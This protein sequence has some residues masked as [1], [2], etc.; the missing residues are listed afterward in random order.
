MIYP[1]G[2]PEQRLIVG[3]KDLTMAFDMVLIDGFSLNPP[4][5]KFHTIDIPGGNGSIDL[6]E[7]VGGD[8][9]Y[10]NREQEFT[11]KV[12]YA[13]RF[14]ITK[15]AVSNYLHGRYF[16]YEL[17]WDPGY[18]YKGRFSVVSYSHIAL[19]K[20]R[21]GEIVVH[22]TA[23][24]YKYRDD[25]VYRINAA[26]GTKYFFDSGRK[27][28][29]PV[30]Q[31][32]MP[33][34]IIWKNTISRVGIGTFRLNNILFQEGINEIYINS[35]DINDTGWGDVGSGSGSGSGGL[36]LTWEE[37]RQYTWDEFGRL[38]LDP[39]TPGD[40][41]KEF[42]EQQAIALYDN[43]DDTPTITKQT[44]L[45]A[46]QWNDLHN[47]TW[48]YMKDNGWTWDGLNYH[49]GGSFDSDRGEEAPDLNGAVAIITYEWGDL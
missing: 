46:Y 11:F 18:T 38:T 31:T 20:G 17:N 7:L 23:D 30:I 4:E 42:M 43:Y 13:D 22:V 47:Q 44:F 35:Y 39:L 26:G 19:A 25:K 41:T 32:A 29:R 5:P 36:G 10:N 27:P 3:G 37:A 14:E 24:P 40:I 6:T 28:V 34:S 12:I 16:E 45:K 49:P 2:Y 1:Y 15:T 8:V 48:N 9:T 21:L 33:L